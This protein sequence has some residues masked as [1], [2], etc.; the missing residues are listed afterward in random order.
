MDQLT[1]MRYRK[2]ID[3][4]EFLKE[5][6]RLKKEIMALRQAVRETELRTD[7]TNDLLEKIFNFAEHAKE[8]FDNGGI[9]VKKEIFIGMGGNCTLLNKKLSIDKHLWLIPIENK[10]QSVE[11]KMAE[12]ELKKTNGV[13]TKGDFDEINLMLRGLVDDVRTEII[14]Y[15]SYIYIPNLDK[16]ET[17]GIKRYG[18]WRHETSDR[19]AENSEKVTA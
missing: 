4:E 12:W 10:K 11:S 15:K 8:R 16:I 2:L 7:K 6:T 18:G 9:Q 17:F 19:I 5:K 3:D 13:A 1:Q 14:D